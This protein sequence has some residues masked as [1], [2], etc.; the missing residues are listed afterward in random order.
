MTAFSHRTR[1][2]RY[3]FLG[4]LVALGACAP[5]EQEPRRAE[6]EAGKTE[7]GFSFTVPSLGEGGGEIRLSDLT[8]RVVLLDFWA[9][10][11][12]PCRAELPVLNS[13]QA[14]FE[15]RGFTLVGLTVDRGEPD[16]V[17]QAVEKLG[18]TY[19]VGLAGTDIQ[20]AYGGIRAVPTKFLLNRN[21][22]ILQDYIGV[23]PEA[24]LRA[25]IEKALAR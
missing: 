16:T 3:A 22:G 23:V 13:L 2:T 14:D 11:C 19:P 8:G 6:H 1:F 10:W 17:A 7:P 4:L 12:L 9:T 25:D 15:D 20:Q 21:G 24:M 18:L 5:R